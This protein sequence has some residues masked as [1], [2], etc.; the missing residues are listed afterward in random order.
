LFSLDAGSG[1]YNFGNNTCPRHIRCRW[2]LGHIFG[3]KKC[4]LW[5]G[6]Y[7][8]SCSEHSTEISPI[9]EETPPSHKNKKNNLIKR[10]GFV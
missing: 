6:K 1:I 3:G 8:I 2:N 9:Y 4:I 10:Y 5:A 7:G